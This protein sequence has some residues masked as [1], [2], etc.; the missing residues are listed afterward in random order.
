MTSSLSRQNLGFDFESP[1][2]RFGPLQTTASNALCVP[3]IYGQVKA[4]GNKI[5]Q[6]S[7]STFNT[8]IAFGEGQINEIFNVK[9]NDYDLYP[10]LS[11]DLAGCSCDASYVGNGAKSIDYRVTGNTPEAK[12]ALVGGLKNTAYAALTIKTGTKVSRGYMNVTANISGKLVDVYATASSTPTKTYS[13]NPAWCILD[14]LTSPSGCAMSIEELDIQ[15]FIYASQYCDEEVSAYSATGTVSCAK[16]SNTVIGVNTKFLTEAKV[17]DHVTINGITRKITKIVSD[18]SLTVESAFSTANI[19]SQIMTIHEARF[20]LNLILDERKSRRVW[21]NKMLIVCRGNLTY[22][23]DN[24]LALVIEQDVK[25]EDYIQD[26]TPDNII[27]GSEY[28]E[29]TPKYKR[30]DILR[31]RYIYPSDQCA[32]VFAVAEADGFLSDPPIVQEIEAFGVTNFKQASRLA[33]YYLNQANNCNKFISFATTQVALDRTVGDVITLTSTFLGYE[34]KKMR[35]VD[36][37]QAQSGQIKITCR[38]HNGAESATLT[39]NFKDSTG[40]LIYK[41]ADTSKKDVTIQYV[42]PC[43][44]NSPLVVSVLGQ[45]ITISLETGADGIIITTEAEIKLAIETNIEA[46]KLVMVSIAPSEINNSNIVTV[47]DEY[48]LAR[49]YKN[50]V[51]NP[52][53]EN[54]ETNAIKIKYID[55][56]ASNQPL[57]IAVSDKNINIS[58]ATNAWGEVTT[59]A[60]QIKTAIDVNLAV[61]ALVTVEYANVVTTTDKIRIA[62]NNNDLVFSSVEKSSNADDITI[63]YTDRYAINQLLDVTV[64]NKDINVLLSSDSDGKIKTTAN[65]VI[66]KINEKASALVTVANAEGSDGSGVVKAMPK[67]NLAG[68]TVGLYGDR[69]GSVEPEFNLVDTNDAFDIPE[70]VTMFQASQS[71]DTLQF[72][73]NEISG[74]GITYEIREGSS[75]EAMSVVKSGLTGTSYSTKLTG[76]GTKYYLIKAITKYGIYSQNAAGS[77]LVVTDIPQSNVLVVTDLVSPAE[78]EFENTHIYNGKLKLDFDGSNWTTDHITDT[79]ET[80]NTERAYCQNEKWGCPVKTSGSYTSQVYD[81]GSVLL[82][83]F[84]INYQTYLCNNSGSI[85]LDIKTSDDNE[86]WSIWPSVPSGAS[87]SI[88]CRYYQLVVT[89]DSPLK[90]QIYLSDCILSVDV[91]DIIEHYNDLII[92]DAQVGYNLQFASN[93]QSKNKKSFNAIPAVVITPEA[94]N[95]II[96]TAE[97][98]NKTKNSVTIRLKNASNGNFITGRFDCLVKGY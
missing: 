89:F 25:S 68:G 52:I 76:T 69:L 45:D 50:L 36:I 66:G 90:N 85:V 26:F 30:C 55:P 21:L 27:A 5:W 94:Q 54:L 56:C 77:I 35:I 20:T 38:E 12:A 23:A 48:R 93:P 49:S 75:W 87:K 37:A 15:S 29:T 88:T 64:T 11:S 53:D 59:T 4:A 10:I 34:K 22:N 40:N 78:G 63:K 39:T 67:T 7:G 1:V 2:Y 47:I 79:W 97:Y 8:L 61:L 41:L 51:Y 91:P 71:S 3:I 16:N 46:S 28:F 24:K 18:N 60:T 17:G 70:D 82:S 13:N 65:E 14:F 31:M 19:P 72:N 95:G 44:A 80:N 57:S 62:G 74:S 96:I 92:S 86:T 83:D 32:R 73:W 33:W 43:D 81:L 58:L 98:S 42:D 9:L 84:K 6:S